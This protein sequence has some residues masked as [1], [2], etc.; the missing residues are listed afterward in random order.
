VFIV[1]AYDIPDDRRRTRLYKGLSHFGTP[2]QESVFEFH[3][4]GREFIEMKR[5][6]A[7]IVDDRVDQ[8]R[9]YHLCES[10]R[11]R[12]EATSSSRMTSDPRALIA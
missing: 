9:Y 5:I 1:V 10:C 12:I 7:G 8:V 11:H 3:L 6:V 4:T 2:V